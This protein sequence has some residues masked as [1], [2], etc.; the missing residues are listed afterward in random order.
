MYTNY[1]ITLFMSRNLLIEQKYIKF[2]I[3]F[4]FRKT[5]IKTL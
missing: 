5:Y 2:I 4:S 1:Q 3:N